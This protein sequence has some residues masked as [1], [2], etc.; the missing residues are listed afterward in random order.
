MADNNIKINRVNGIPIEDTEL[1]NNVN[2][3]NNELTTQIDQKASDIDLSIERNRI[4]N[5]VTFVESENGEVELL[6]DSTTD[7]NVEIQ[8]VVGQKIDDLKNEINVERNRINSISSLSEGS[9]T[10]DAELIDIRTGAD[11]T[12]YDNAGSAVRGQV[13]AL[14]SQIKE[15]KESILNIHN[16]TRTNSLYKNSSYNV[17]SAPTCQAVFVDDDGESAVLTKLKDFAVSKDIPWT[18][19]LYEDSKILKT[20]DLIAQ[21]REL[22]DK[23][24]WEI[25]GHDFTPTT[26]KTEEE[27]INH[28]ESLL[29]TLRCMGFHVYSYMYPQGNYND[30]VQKITSRYFRS[31]CTTGQLRPNYYNSMRMYRL[32]RIEI[33]CKGYPVTDFNTIKGYI[34][35]AYKNNGLLI[36]TT[37]IGQM[38]DDEISLMNDV[39]DY[40]ISK[41]IKCTTLN[42]ALDDFAPI[43]YSVNKDLSPT[44]YFYLHNNGVLESNRAK[45][46][47]VKEN[48]Y[49][50]SNLLDDY[51]ENMVTITVVSN[52]NASGFPRNTGGL[53]ITYRIGGDKGYSY[54]TYKL[55]GLNNLYYRTSTN[56]G[57][58]NDWI[59]II[60]AENS[61]YL[62]KATNTYNNDTPISDFPKGVTTFASN[63]ANGAGFPGNYA[64]LVTTYKI[65]DNG[66]YRQEF[67]KYMSNEL[68]S[69]YVDSDGNWTDWVKISAV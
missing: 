49:N 4:D 44:E 21:T 57:T 55:F 5:L 64:G 37:H 61:N 2:I 16:E 22:Q 28:Y 43:I 65:A 10:G 23:L 50:N 24:G 33:P 53:L 66:W 39:V 51:E 42:K 67:R 7:N 26:S 52:S 29:F 11:G 40:I 32:D 6:L 48:T 8:D 31:A 58:W 27:L 54:Q 3:M 45:L 62:I 9:T 68:W 12:V 47:Y 13:N 60:T 17:D 56:T 25:A 35:T 59:G 20:D 63:L 34:D 18:I 46:K 36:F 38:S 41:N 14:K 69:R 30:N 1:K 19:A 15:S